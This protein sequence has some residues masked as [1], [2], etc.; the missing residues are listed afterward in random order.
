MADP[1]CTFVFSII[2]LCTT[3]NVLRDTICVIM[4]GVP[5]DINYKKLRSELETLDH[6]KM[7]HNLCVW[8]LTLNKN[9]VSVHLA[10]DELV[11]T[12]IIL[13]GATAMLRQR[14]KFQHITIQVE[15]YIPT[16]SQCP[17][18]LMPA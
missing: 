10:L 8:S 9:A 1:I 13:E 6:V 17:V 4:E 12:Q 15:R 18:C 16:M 5:Q 11:D 3:F 7:V 2:V 14:Y